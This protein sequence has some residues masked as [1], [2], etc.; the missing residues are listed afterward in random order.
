MRKIININM[1]WHFLADMTGVPVAI[2][3][4]AESIDLPH[5][6]NAMDGQDGDGDYFRGKCCYFKQLNQLPP[7]KKYYLEFLGAAMSADVYIDGKHYGHHDGG[8]SLWRVDI[9]EN[10][11]GLIA[12]LVDNGENGN[13][14]PQKAEFTLYGGL[15]REVNLLCLEESHFDVENAGGPGIYVTS[16]LEDSDA[17]ASVEVFPVNFREG[18]TISYTLRGSEGELVASHR[19]DASRL[20]FRIK[21]AHLWQ[22]R[23]DPYLYSVTAELIEGDS[24]IDQVSARFGCRSV[25]IDPQRGFLLNGEPYPLR[26][27]S[28]HQD[29]LALGNALLKEHHEQDMDL[30]CEMGANAIRLTHYQQDPYFYDLCDRRGMVVWTEIPYSGQPGSRENLPEQLRELV[31]QNY[32]HPSIAVWGIACTAGEDKAALEELDDLVRTLDQHRITA[33]GVKPLYPRDSVCLEIPDAV[34]WHQDYGWQGGTAEMVGSWLDQLHGERPKLPLALGNYGCEAMDLHSSHPVQG[35]YTES[36]QALYHESLIRQLFARQ[37]L[38]GSFCPMFDFAG[39]GLKKAVVPGPD[40]S[41]LVSFDRKY[42][43]D[44]FYAYK[45][46]LSQEPFVHICGKRYVNRVEDV[47]SVTVYSNQPEVELFAGSKSLGI[48]RSADHFFKFQVLNV[49]E[50]V[51]TAVAG[52]CRD[53]SLINKV[54]IFPEIYRLRNRKALVKWNEITQREGYFCLNDPLGQIMATLPGKLWAGKFLLNLRRKLEESQKKQLEMDNLAAFHQ[55]I[56]G[57][58]VLRLLHMANGK[59]TKEEALKI[60]E[61]LNKIRKKG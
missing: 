55:R 7:A 54:Q 22:G 40:R 8:Y 41:G 56:S 39:H 27:V 14:Y 3:E 60:N 10:P 38:W 48:Q 33:M 52:D 4:A 21:N 36:Y 44:A 1:D 53:E 28:R 35:D 34:G 50:T 12:V 31:I 13:V 57:F 5:T 30:I 46:W 9:T 16:L 59:I 25:Q 37:Y 24:V 43:K 15:Y 23:R 6:W 19:T 42:K 49:G 11:K 58:T 51:I 47:T 17:V 20:K 29:R 61:Q 26:G 32:N 45:A 2:P 18:Q